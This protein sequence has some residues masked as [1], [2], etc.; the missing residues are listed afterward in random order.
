MLY[1]YCIYLSI[2]LSFKHIISLP[3]LTVNI[4]TH[5][6]Q[7][8]IIILFFFSLISST[9]MAVEEKGDLSFILFFFR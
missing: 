7:F 9:S 6:L 1:D 2:I 5:Q 3:I 8:L 4:L